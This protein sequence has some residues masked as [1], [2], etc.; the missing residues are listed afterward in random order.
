MKK[1]RSDLA[2]DK[3]KQARNTIRA[4]RR[5]YKLSGDIVRILKW[6]KESGNVVVGFGGAEFEADV[7]NISDMKLQFL[8]H[9]HQYRINQ[10]AKRI[11][12]GDSR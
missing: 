4:L 12:Y 1:Y 9:L 5:N 3:M 8:L 11:N 6:N 10:H 7:E 2:T